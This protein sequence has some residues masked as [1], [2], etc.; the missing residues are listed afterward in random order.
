MHRIS[1]HGI[2]N[3]DVNTRSFIVHTR[4]SA[5][6]ATG[7]KVFMIDFAL[8]KLRREF[9]D[10]NDWREWKAIQDKEGAVEFVMQR[11]LEGGFVYR[12]S[13][14]YRKLDEEFKSEA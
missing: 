9:G 4:P 6:A 8:C 11:Y 1:D 3:E 14:V 7:Y 2:L 5:E 13:G 12:R 10:D